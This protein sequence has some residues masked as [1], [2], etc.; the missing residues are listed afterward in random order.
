MLKFNK[1]FYRLNQSITAPSVRLIDESGKQIGIV[2]RLE[3]LAKAQESDV[4]L[5]EIAPKA[6][7]PVCRLIDFKKFRYLQS[8]K[9]KEEKKKTKVVE[10]KEI[11]MGPFV[12]PR[13]LEIR[14]DR[15]REFIKKGNRVKLSVRFAGRQI[16]HPEFGHGLLQKIVE[17]LSDLAQVEREAKFEGRNLSLILGKSKGKKKEEEQNAQSQNQE[18]GQKKI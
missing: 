11:R 17:A 6:N 14:I 9:E 12:A 1:P 16:T 2:N 3:A 18:S 4:D 5:V 7:P 13:D 10:L 8:R 15:I